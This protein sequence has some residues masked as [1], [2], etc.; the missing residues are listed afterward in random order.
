[1]F[2][3][4]KKKSEPLE[5]NSDASDDL[6]PVIMSEAKKKIMLDLSFVQTK[7]AC[8][9]GFNHTITLSNDGTAYSFGRNKEGQLGLGHNNDVSIP[10]PI[11]NLP[12]ISL[13]SCG[14]FF[15]VFVD[16]EG[17][18]W[19][20]GGNNAVQLGTGNTTKYNVP[21]KLLNIPPV[22][23]VDCGFQYT[24]IITNDSNL[25][26]WGNNGCKQLCHGD[27]N[28]RSKPQ[29]T[30]FS[31]ISKISAGN[32]HSLFQNH[33]GEIFACGYNGNGEC[34][35]GHFNEYQATPSLIPNLPSNID[36]VI[37][38]T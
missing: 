13:I 34:G 3:I 22:V 29:K 36:T 6:D 21:Q 24:L 17:F 5:A 10:T 9:C 8:A 7:I 35:L 32:H 18:I 30:S 25:W 33:K 11:P 38:P 15:T 12:Q 19:S 26:S 2:K 16:H 14:G 31:N 20:F 27:T 1:M 37:K 23:S 28:N 4:A